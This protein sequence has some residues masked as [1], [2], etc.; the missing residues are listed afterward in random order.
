MG[1]IFT[2]GL[3][4]SVVRA[5]F[6]V[7]G[8]VPMYS[9]FTKF[10]FS[11]GVYVKGLFLEGARWDRKT[12]LLAES[13]PKILF[14]PVPVIWMKPCKR[15]DLV[16]ECV[17]HIPVYKTSERRGVLSTTGH[18]TNY[19]IGM[20]IPTDKPEDHWVQRGVAM[21]CQLDN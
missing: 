20:L 15:A 13:L 9:A 11:L 2:P 1:D 21:L 10:Y 6:R 16:E 8:L 14:D 3:Q 17:Y 7:E 4:G 12:H 18:S 19:V 5:L